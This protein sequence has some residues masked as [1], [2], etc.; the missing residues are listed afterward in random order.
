MVLGTTARARQRSSSPA[1]TG[2][3][4]ASRFYST[5]TVLRLRYAMS[6]Y[7]AIRGGDMLCQSKRKSS[8]LMAAAE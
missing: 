6:A 8:C 2:T 4:R 7:G 1:A 3:V 5:G